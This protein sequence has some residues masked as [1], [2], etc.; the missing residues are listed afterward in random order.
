MVIVSSQYQIG[1]ECRKHFEHSEILDHFRRRKEK[2]KT[3]ET[4]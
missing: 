1:G 3:K 4:F 2:M